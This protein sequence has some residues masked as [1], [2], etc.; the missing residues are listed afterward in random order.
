MK[1]K[2]IFITGPTGVGK[3]NIA[4]GLA[5][6]LGSE[7]IVGDSVQVNFIIFLEILAL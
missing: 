6:L 2:L 7:I 1:K 4:L 5:K 3:S